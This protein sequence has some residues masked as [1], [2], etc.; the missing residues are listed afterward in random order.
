MATSG[1]YKIVN[2]DNGKYYIGSSDNISHRWYIHKCKLNHNRHANKHL[3]NAW[4]K[5]GSNNFEF[6]VVAETFPNELLETEQLY[7]DECKK[8]PDTSYNI[9]YDA[10]APMRGRTCSKEHRLKTSRSLIG[11]KRSYETKQK[12]SIARTGM[13]F[14]EEHRKNI[15]I[16]AIGRIPWNKGKP[17]SEEYKQKISKSKKGV[18]HG[19]KG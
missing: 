15:G 7:L 11:I 13:I 4:N 19:T 1:V 2:K 17:L 12:I 18:Y 5:Y 14:T 3:Q 10:T 6:I 9:S 16:G 8:F